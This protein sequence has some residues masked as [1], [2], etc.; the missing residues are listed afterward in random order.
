MKKTHLT[1]GGVNFEAILDKNEAK[2]IIFF[3]LCIIDFF[4]IS[5]RCTKRGHI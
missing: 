4:D 3:I 1:P 5:V 2:R